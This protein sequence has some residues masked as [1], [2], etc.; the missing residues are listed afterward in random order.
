MEAVVDA[1][2]EI[3]VDRARF[4]YPYYDGCYPKIGA[5]GREVIRSRC[6]ATD[7]ASI[8][9]LTMISY[10]D[11]IVGNL[12]IRNVPKRTLD[13]LKAAAKRHHRSVQ[14]E[15]LEILN[16]SSVPAGTAMVE[17]LNATRE[18]GIRDSKAGMRAIREARDER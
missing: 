7:A 6:F 18:P 2:V 5:S 3:C 1:H 17:W 8:A 11:I 15:V 4:Y 16:R 13:S 12:L 10:D 14:A 9:G